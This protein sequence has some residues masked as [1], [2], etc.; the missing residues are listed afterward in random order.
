MALSI[1]KPGQGYWTR[2]LSAVGA[3]TLVLAGV[4]W[5]VAQL[6]AWIASENTLYYQAGVATSL[7]VGFGLA[8]YFVLNKP[9]I[10]DFMIATE[11]EMKKV[12]W[13]SRKEIIGSTIVVIGG[14]VL[15]ALLLF[16]INL[17]FGALFRAIGIL[18]G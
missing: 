5:L 15:I 10:V 7:I 3:G 11:A 2:V 4:A 13:P 6:E 16:V 18:E 1:Y 12:N 9:R 14:T 17:A 8:I